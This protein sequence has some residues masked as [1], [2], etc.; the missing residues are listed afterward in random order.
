MPRIVFCSMAL[1]ASA[2]G[3]ISA[4]VNGRL[5]RVTRFGWAAGGGLE[6]ASDRAD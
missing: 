1:A 4:G 6:A 5:Q 3:N 2:A